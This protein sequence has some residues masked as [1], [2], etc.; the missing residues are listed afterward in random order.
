MAQGLAFYLR[1]GW[2]PKAT[3]DTSRHSLSCTPSNKSLRLPTL[4]S[5]RACRHPPHGILSRDLHQS[6]RLHSIPHD[7]TCRKLLRSGIPWGFFTKNPR[8]RLSPPY[9]ISC[10]DLIWSSKEPKVHLWELTTPIVVTSH[11][12]PRNPRF[13][14]RAHD[15]KCRDLTCFSI[16]PKVYSKSSWYQMSW[17]L[18]LF[19]R[20]PSSFRELT[21]SIVV[22][23]YEV[24]RNPTLVERE[25]TTSIVVTSNTLQ[26][27]PRFTPRAHDIKFH[28]LSCV[29]KDYKARAKSSRHE[30]S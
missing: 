29:S 20:T 14:P 2:V 28:D 9:D 27:N 11:I 26:W 18:F 23:S 22:T 15:I 3:F 5:S 4:K 16:E 25:F 19:N 8:E 17:P 30:M 21:T 6:P 12:L 7:T 10:H 24:Q 1:N 13:A